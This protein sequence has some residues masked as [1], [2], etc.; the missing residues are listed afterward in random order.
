[1]A[2]CVITLFRLSSANLKVNRAEAE[3][4]AEAGGSGRKGRKCRKGR[5]CD[6]LELNKERMNMYIEAYK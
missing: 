1:M 4:E 5:Y 2:E 3:A 6:G